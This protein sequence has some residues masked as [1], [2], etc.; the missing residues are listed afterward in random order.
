MPRLTSPTATTA[1]RLAGA[2]LLL[3]PAVLS[4]C[5]AIYDDTKGWANRLEASIL[6]AAHELEE[7]PAAQDPAHYTPEAVEPPRP[8]RGQ[9]AMV[10]TQSAMAQADKPGASPPEA[11]PQAPAV[12]PQAAAARKALQ[13]A[14][15]KPKGV[16]GDAASTLMQPEAAAEQKA[17]AATAGPETA[18]AAAGAAKGKDDTTKKPAAPALP[19]R[20]PQVAKAAAEKKPMEKK[21]MEEKPAPEQAAENKPAEKPQ[22]SEAARDGDMAKAGSDV[23]MV[24]HLSSLRSEEAAKREWNDLQQTYPGPLGS[25]KAEIRRTELGEKGVFYRVLAGPLPSR[26]AAK[27]ACAALKAKNLRQYCRVLPSGSEAKAPS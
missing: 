15:P 3:L 22:S 5:D 8:P 14:Q 19:K 1:A 18:D 25:L 9:Q 16:V 13:P 6:K 26:S 11:K 10:P 20:K 17:P 2:V 12:P 23:A 7:D 21:T 4:G 27:E 24:L